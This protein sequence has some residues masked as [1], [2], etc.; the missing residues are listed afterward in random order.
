MTHRGSSLIFVSVFALAW[1]GASWMAEA[2]TIEILSSIADCSE[3]FENLAN[4]LQPGDELVLHGGIYS[5]NCRRAIT[6]NGT[7]ANPII[8]RA[9]TGESPLLTRPS[10]QLDTQNNIEIVNSS[11]L[12]IRG[13]RFQGGSAGVR[14]I[15]GHHITLE[16]CEIFDTGNNAI[17]MNSGNYDAFVIRRNHIHHTGLSMSGTTEGEGMYVGCNDNTCRATNS[18]IDGN[19]I[20]HLRATS[21]GGNDGI[22]IKVGSY[23]NV[24][25]N[26]V[27]HDTNIGRQYPCIFVYGG[28][29]TVNIV[30]GNAMWNCGEAIQVVSDAIVRNNLILNSSVTGITAAPHSQVAQMRNVTIVNNTI[31]GHPDCLYIRWS[32]ATN[33]S[34]ANNAIYCPGSTAVNASGLTGSGIVVQTNY[35]QGSLS[36]ATIDNVRFFSGG[37]STSAFVNPAQ[38]DFWPTPTSP[39]I[40]S[41]SAAMAPPLDFNERARTAPPDAGAYETDG[42]SANPGWRVGPGFKSAGATTELPA[43]PTNLHVQ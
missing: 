2:A 17:S 32:G 20:H 12:I 33:M 16:D 14:F 18:L 10:N 35:V 25:R 27:I 4:G 26:N 5:Q 3:E 21:D 1:S 8:I 7:A 40:G 36:G 19:Y 39:L 6:A 29:S 13:L 23:G 37:N 34:L 43:A 15:G 24:V 31:Y 9:A 22:E 38:L 42:S 11:Y 41:A 28:G 30:E